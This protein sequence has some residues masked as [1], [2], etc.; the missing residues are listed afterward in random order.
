MSFLDRF[1]RNAPDAKEKTPETKPA[2]PAPALPRTPQAAL[3]I[4]AEAVAAGYNP[5]F[6]LSE[7]KPDAE[8]PKPQVEEHEMILELGDFLHRIPPQLVSVGPHEVH[9]E[10]RFDIDAMAASVA[11]G[12]TTV[13]LA[14][15]YKRVPQIFRDE[16]LPSDKVEIRFPW[17]KVMKLLSEA[18]GAQRGAGLSELAADALAQRLKAKRTQRN[19][20]FT[21]AAPAPAGTQAAPAPAPAPALAGPP[22]V[23]MPVIELPPP[24]SAE[25][26]AAMTRE[27]LLRSRDVA[28]RQVVR[29]KGEYE[30]AIATLR[31]ERKAVVGDRDRINGEL[32]KAKRD[33]HDK[34]EQIEFEKTVTAKSSENLKKA[35]QEFEAVRAERDALARQQAQLAKQLASPQKPGAKLS[36]VADAPAAGAG[37]ERSQKEYQ[38]Q[39]EELNRR[40]AMLE[41]GQRESA[42]ELSKEREQR[43]K[44][45]RQLSAADRL[46]SE[47]A[48]QLEEA[49]ASL[50]REFEAAARNRET[51]ITRTLKEFQTQ[52]EAANLAR[53]KLAAELE[54]ARTAPPAAEA[55]AAAPDPGWES[56]AVAQLE[57]DVASYRERIKKL[58]QERD[59]ISGEKEQL[60]TQLAAKAS[61]A[62]AAPMEN[63][64][65]SELGTENQKLQ[66]LLSTTNADR[67]RIAAEL[68][69]AQTALAETGKSHATQLEASQASLSDALAQAKSQLAA[70]QEQIGSL[71]QER[72]ETLRELQ[73]HKAAPSPVAEIREELALVT[74][75]RDEARSGAER[76]IADLRNEIEKLAAAAHAAP[77]N[78]AELK[79]E[80]GKLAKELDAARISSNSTITNLRSDAKKLTYERDA[81]LKEGEQL[82]VEFDALKSES[83]KAAAGFARDLE[84]AHT[85]QEASE[86]GFRQRLEAL[87][88]TLEELQ[89]EHA[90]FDAEK[91]ALAAE[92]TKTRAAHELAS[93]AVASAQTE[94]DQT[95]AILNSAR[96]GLHEKI[97]SLTTEL[98]AARVE[99]DAAVARLTS[100]RDEI[101]TVRA[102]LDKSLA[103][104]TADRDQLAGTASAFATELSVATQQHTAAFTAV[105]QERDSIR[106]A[107]AEV[108]KSLAAVAAERDAA[109]EA[110]SELERK[111]AA[112][113]RS[114]SELRPQI[115]AL[116]AALAAATG[117]IHDKD[118]QIVSLTAERDDF[119]ARWARFSAELDAI[120]QEREGVRA[121]KAEIEASLPT[122]TA[123]RNAALNTRVV[124]VK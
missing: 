23:R 119:T 89:V 42:Q 2:A 27:E 57:T 105:E 62:A 109:R 107:A 76:T 48:A 101:R 55:P 45:E 93:T 99:H 71:A 5:D 74:K 117:A 112:A 95:L 4:A 104:L 11:A 90:R 102:E 123:A 66:A 13:S 70:L 3:K 43:T 75:E 14:E 6:M 83:D 78:A 35:Q 17:Q 59:T 85:S 53:T 41:G 37:P 1:K 56:R 18:R 87:Q 39:L 72:D 103:A 120:A 26:D 52:L 15:I 113:E 79:A 97:A 34:V 9:T 100:E 12:H 25:D 67:E 111:L 92:L 94:H 110:S 114:D 30:R 29:V 69:E 60:A 77:I 20:V 115:Q 68:R 50:R 86:S 38:R 51:E 32:E 10:L 22:T 19:V 118:G 65:S 49:N 36:V 121:A 40:I 33:I 82:M 21:K 28:N 63:A 8:P 16:V 64:S 91:T 108:E 80:A 58:L 98:D 84:A 116:E 24:A 96:D 54:L 61:E 47:A 73:A 31:E 7:I 106:A 122:A 81:A 88:K 124:R 44:L 46:K